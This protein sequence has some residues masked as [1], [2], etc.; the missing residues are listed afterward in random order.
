MIFAVL[1]AI[2]CHGSGM[3]ETRRCQRSRWSQQKRKSGDG[4]VGEYQEK[5]NT[6]SKRI[7]V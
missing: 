1:M 6:A 2:W 3:K 4:R 5:D 7:T